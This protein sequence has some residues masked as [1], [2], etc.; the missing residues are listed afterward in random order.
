M[1]R[2]SVDGVIQMPPTRIRRREGCLWT[3]EQKETGIPIPP[4]WQKKATWAVL[5]IPSIGTASCPVAGQDLARSGT[6]QSRKGASGSAC[7]PTVTQQHESTKMP[8]SVQSHLL[9]AG[10]SREI[11]CLD[12]LHVSPNAYAFITVVAA[13]FRHSAFPSRHLYNVQS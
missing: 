13:F 7:M 9:E 4:L 3:T 11:V 8:N 2:G 5:R 1:Y 6:S 12:F 10:Y